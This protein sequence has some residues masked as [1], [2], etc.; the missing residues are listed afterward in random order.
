MILLCYKMIC[1]WMTWMISDQILRRYYCFW[2]CFYFTASHRMTKCGL[3]FCVCAYKALWCFW[4][5][6]VLS[7]FARWKVTAFCP[8]K[9]L[10]FPFCLVWTTPGLIKVRDYG[11]CHLFHNHSLIFVKYKPGSFW[12]YYEFGL[13]GV[14]WKFFWHKNFVCMNCETCL[15]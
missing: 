13:V 10:L 12:L 3:V 5:H 2:P 14:F 7:V 15:V 4:C 11:Y 6:Q 8:L 9:H 1:E